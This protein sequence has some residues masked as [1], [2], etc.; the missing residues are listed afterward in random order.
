MG[1]TGQPQPITMDGKFILSKNE[2]YDGFLKTVGVPAELAAKMCAAV[3]TVDVTHSATGVTRVA[4]AGD[5][6]FTS[7]ITFGQDSPSEIAGLT[8]TIN[9]NK[10]GTGYAGS[11]KLGSHA[12]TVSLETTPD[13]LCQ[14]MTVGGVTCKRQYQ[15]C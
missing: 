15:K 3:P 9:A 4:T 12:G 10:T 6:T 13:G 7:T 11:L 1:T 5:K 2:N 14:C 8:Y